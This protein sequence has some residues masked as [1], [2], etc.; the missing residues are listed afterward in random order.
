[1]IFIKRTEAPVSTN[2]SEAPFYFSTINPYYPDYQMPNCTCYAFG[3][4]LELASLNNINIREYNVAYGN[5][6]RWGDSGYIGNTY[7]KGD[8]P[9]VGA[10]AVW[11][12]LGEAGHVAIVEEVHDDGSYQCSN[13]GYYRPIDTTDWHY[14]FMTDVTKDNVIYR[15]GNEWS[16]Y[17]FKYFLYPPY[18]DIP[19][20]TPKKKKKKFPWVL[21]ANKFRNRY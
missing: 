9:K 16:N 17:R 18:I 7:E 14:F 5:G 11:E 1:M 12:E 6:G 21:Y 19:T 8:S 3:R 2:E 13:S 10:I 15:N 20:P 4:I